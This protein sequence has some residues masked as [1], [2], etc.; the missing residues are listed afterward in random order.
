MKILPKARKRL[1]AVTG[2]AVETSTDLAAR[3]F[4]FLTDK[5]ESKATEAHTLVECLLTDLEA[6]TAR[7]A[8]S[9]RDKGDLTPLRDNDLKVLAENMEVASR[10]PW[11]KPLPWAKPP[12]K[13]Q[14]VA[15][16]L[17]DGV[18]WDKIVATK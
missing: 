2:V 11:L 13:E 6:E 18:D 14:T 15:E 8:A 16:Q 3:A 9:V 7:I 4:E 12:A 17:K 1:S 5:A 10:T